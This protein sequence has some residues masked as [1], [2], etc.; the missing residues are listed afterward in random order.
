MFLL[1]PT[2]PGCAGQNPQSHKMVV[3]VCVC[4]VWDYMGKPV[5]E[6]TFTHSYGASM[7]DTRHLMVQWENN[8]SRCTD[9]PAGCNPIR[10]IGAPT[11]IIPSSLRQMPFLSQPS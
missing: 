7:G 11:Y 1:V 8:K 10:T 3:C 2:H 4:V 5:A 9:K 6:E